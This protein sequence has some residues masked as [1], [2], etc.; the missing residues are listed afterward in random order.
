MSNLQEMLGMN[1]GSFQQAEQM[2][3][4][5]ISKGHTGIWLDLALL[6]AAQ[7]NKE[8]NIQALNE[9]EKYFPNCPK[10]R[11]TRSWMLLS[12][13]KLKEGFDHIEAGRECGALGD[14]VEHVNGI[15]W[16]GKASLKGKTIMVYGEGGQ[17]DQIM[18]LRSCKILHEMGANVIV[19]CVKH[20]F[21][22]FTH[23]KWVTTVISQDKTNVV[24]YDYWIPMMS[25]FRLCGLDES[26]MYTESFFRHI[27][28]DFL[29]KRIIPKEN[30]KLNVGLRWSGNPQFEH[31]QLRVFPP[32]KMFDAV[33]LD[34]VNL[35]SLQKDD[36]KTQLPS[37]IVNLEPLLGDWVQTAMAIQQLDLVITSC[38]S[39]A[40]LSAAMGK[41]TWV[42]IPAMP[43]YPWAK[44]G[45]KSV[46]YPS[47]TLFRQKCYGDWNDAFSELKERFYR[48]VNGTKIKELS[49]IEFFEDHFDGKLL[50]SS[51][52]TSG[53]ELSI[54][55]GLINKYN[56][57]KILEIGVNTGESSKIILDSCKCIEKYT[58]I[59]I[60]K[61]KASTMMKS[62]MEERVRLKDDVGKFIKKDP[63]VD[64][65]VSDNGTKDFKTEEQYDLVFV[66]G[67]HSYEWA[68]YDTEFA[69]S[70]NPKII[71]WHDYGTEAGVTKA[72][73]ELD[74]SLVRILRTRI[75]YLIN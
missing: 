58:G 27:D 55:S 70:L 49:T 52:Y 5:F 41:P 61:E 34:N 71:V 59:D 36:E 60:T 23:C 33:N 35:Y 51:Y 63:R 42:I 54:I 21:K 37:N 46:W 6:F 31:S 57:K 24:S 74:D 67:N 7:G 30:N 38:T 68:K 32:N 10:L 66:D 13:G 16:D 9:Y 73:D 25:S 75:M 1:G 8:G 50:S 64:I 3:L 11:F 72:V 48:K 26:T 45:N 17:G 12:E 53:E 18:G 14:H 19:A 44:P 29:W 22:L 4:D 40:H 20:L 28:G 56:L 62:Q 39:I 65:F 69:K 47:V 43:Y 15:K 2:A